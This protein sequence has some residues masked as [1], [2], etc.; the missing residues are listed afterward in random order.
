[1]WVA[2]GVRASMQIA[3]AFVRVHVRVLVCVSERGRAC[4][5]QAMLWSVC[6]LSPP[7]HRLLLN[8]PEPGTEASRLVPGST[9]V[10]SQGAAAQQL[11]GNKLSVQLVTFTPYF[12]VA[13]PPL[14]AISRVG[15]MGTWMIAVLSG[16]AAVSLPY[17]YLSLFVRPVEAYEVLAMEDQYK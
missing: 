4:T 10:V 16:Y 1:V 13:P 14:Q 7:A 8:L 12:M 11:Q 2:E 3:H 15:V 9:P 17:S 6:S 5:E